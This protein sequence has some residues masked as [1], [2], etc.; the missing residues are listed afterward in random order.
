MAKGKQITPNFNEDEFRCKGKDCC[1]GVC[2]IDYQLVFD[3]QKLRDFIKEKTG[4]EHPFVI[5]SGYRCPKHNISKEV[6]GVPNS[7]HPTGH[8][9]DFYVEGLTIAQTWLFIEKMGI[10]NFIQMGSYPEERPP[11]IHVGNTKDRPYQRW[12]KRDGKYYYLF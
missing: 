12:V 2:L 8:A 1:G 6:G 11:I 3:L 4:K 10:N 7:A 9:I 5:T